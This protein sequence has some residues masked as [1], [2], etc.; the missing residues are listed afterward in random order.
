VALDRY[1]HQEAERLAVEA[2]K[3]VAAA[4]KGG[5]PL[6]EA[7][8]LFYAELPKRADPAD[9]KKDKKKDKKADEKKA[10]EKAGDKRDADDRP[11]LTYENHPGRPVVETTLPFNIAN[12]PIPG[13][14]QSADLAKI[15]FGLEK[16][17]DAPPDALAFEAGYLTIQLKEKT[18]ASRELWDKNKEFY[19]TAMRGA[20]ANDA[21]IA[22]LKRLHGQLAGDAKYTNAIID[23]KA[24]KGSDAPAP[25]DDDPGE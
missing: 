8:D 11:A 24:Q 3:K 9:K 7:L 2:S 25:M 22:Y 1:L 12:D 14:R 23:D 18:P 17:G 20:K 6:K 5:K 21:L 13:V 15:A 19:L 16:P 4:V 10:D